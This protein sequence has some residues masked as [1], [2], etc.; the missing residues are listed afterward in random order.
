[1]TIQTLASLD[2]IQVA[3]RSSRGSICGSTVGAARSPPAPRPAWPAEQG[4]GGGG[5]RAVGGAGGGGGRGPGAR[6][7]LSG[8]ERAASTRPECC[9]TLAVFRG[10]GLG[11]QGPGPKN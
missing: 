10:N 7:L 2:V 11:W 5:Q 8:W 1:M 4:G 3:S 9:S 6:G